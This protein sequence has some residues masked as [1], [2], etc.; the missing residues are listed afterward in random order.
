MWIPL[1]D[2]YDHN[3]CMKLVRGSSRHGS[4]QARRN[5][6]D[7]MEATED[8]SKFGAIVR[9]SI[10]FRYSPTDLSPD[11]HNLG[12]QLNPAF[13]SFVAHSEDSSTVVSF[14]HWQERW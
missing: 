8:V 1:V 13:P 10:D 11:W 7:Q 2:V 4:I 9:W 12:D 6:L 14:A 5:K 3:G